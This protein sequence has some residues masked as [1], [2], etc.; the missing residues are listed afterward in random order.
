MPT[1]R[2]DEEG[3]FVHF[4][5]KK[6]QDLEAQLEE[7][8]ERNEHVLLA[9]ERVLYIGRQVATDLNKAID[10]LAV[11]SRRR[12]AVIELKKDRTPRDMVAQALEYTAWVRRLDYDA[13]SSIAVP[14]FSTRGKPWQSLSEAHQELFPVAQGDEYQDIPW[15]S[16]QI[17][18]LVGQTVQPEI[19]EVARYLRDHNIDVRVLQFAY[20]ESSSGERL[21]NVQLIVGSE[22]MPADAVKGSSPP[23]P[24]LDETLGNVPTVKPVFQE[25]CAAFESTGLSLRRERATIAFDL[26]KGGQPIVSMWPTSA[27]RVIVLILGRRASTLGDLDA[28]HAV[29]Q[30]LGFETVRGT[31]DLSIHVYPSERDRVTSLVES[32]RAHFLGGSSQA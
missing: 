1:F 10:L 26:I 15:N 28:F 13:L 22:R 19:I 24:T 3:R 31:T 29:V 17:V 9:P 8:L 18:V 21:V 11:D 27:Q 20:L 6:A 2:I 5:P 30:E 25:L 7:A 23:T 32:F 14:Y 4:E 12:L 16:S